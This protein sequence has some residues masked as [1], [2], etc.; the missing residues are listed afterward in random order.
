[1]LINDRNV[2]F[3]EIDAKQKGTARRCIDGN[4]TGRNRCVGYC[5]YENH[6]GFLTR[7][8]L[9]AHNCEEK[10]CVYF[11]PQEKQAAFVF[12]APQPTKE[13]LRLAQKET[14]NWEG[15]RVLNCTRRDGVYRLTYVA[16]A[17][18][19][20]ASLRARLQETSGL[21]LVL[22]PVPCCFDTAQK[23]IFDRKEET[24]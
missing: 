12:S 19:D 11:A 16:I 22:Q 9:L 23:L 5:N 17:A 21:P 2:S 6:P 13:L 18:Y 24:V 20:L 3:T 14:A 7:S 8:H 15:L 10:N 4:V 1:M